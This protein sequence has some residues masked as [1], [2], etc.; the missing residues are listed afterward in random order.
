VLVTIFFD[1]EHEECFKGNE[2]RSNKKSTEKD[3]LQNCLSLEKWKNHYFLCAGILGR[4][5][6][7]SKSLT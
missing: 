7:C 6:L 4:I 3:D 1:S 2:L 5:S